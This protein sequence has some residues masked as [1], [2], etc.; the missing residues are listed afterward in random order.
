M[1]V[2]Y[3]LQPEWGVG[4]L[5]RTL[6]GGAL[7]RSS[8]PAARNRLSSP[9]AGTPCSRT[10]S[11]RG[12]GADREGPGGDDH[13]REP[14]GRGLRRYV[15][16]YE[17]GGEDELPESEVHAPPPDTDLLIMMREGRVADARAFLLRRQAL[18]L[19]EERRNDALGAL[20]ASRVMVKP[21]QVGVVQRVLSARRP[22]F[23]LA[24]EVG[25]GK[26]IE[27]GMVF[28][29]LRLSG[30]AARPGGGSPA[31]SPSSGWP[32]CST[33]S[34][35]SSPSWTASGWRGAGARSRSSR[36]GSASR[37]WSPASS[38]S[39]ARRRSSR[40]SPARELG[41]GHRRRGAPPP[42]G[43]GLRR[44]R[45]A[46][47]TPGAPAPDRHADAARP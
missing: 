43:E 30:L 21:H 19:D 7:A 4:H 15:L 6:E 13:R 11:C 1:K 27:A 34:T 9:P 32:S 20:L 8:S 37:G 33:S 22:R 39:L 25:L 10:R 3:A 12:S 5:L 18:V 40:R 38:S 29:A 42:R 23:V 16:R 31:I 45:G 28:S 14:G 17:D 2:R 41:S 35:S 24:D 46:G 36:P 44:R 47:H 26:T